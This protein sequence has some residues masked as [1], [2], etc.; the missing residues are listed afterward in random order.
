MNNSQFKAS[1]IQGLAVDHAAGRLYALVA[2]QPSGADKSQPVAQELIAWSLT[3][4]GSKELV[5][6]SGL[7]SDPLGTGAGLV[8]EKSQLQPS[9]VAPLYDPQGIAI[10]PVGGGGDAP[11]AIEATDLAA[12]TQS[13]GNPAGNTIVQQVATSGS[14]IGDRLSSW[15]SASV[16]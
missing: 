1:A 6:A 13:G 5:A 16:C 11:V 3:P 2:G 8:A 9:G 4:N 15:S 10:D 7:P 14:G 12:E